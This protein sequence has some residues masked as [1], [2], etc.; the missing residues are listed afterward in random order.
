VII[1][2]GQ[3]QEPYKLPLVPNIRASI[4]SLN[5]LAEAEAYKCSVIAEVWFLF[6]LL[7]K[8]A[9]LNVYPIQPKN[10]EKLLATMIEN[11]EKVSSFIVA[12]TLQLSDVFAFS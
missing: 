2:I 3:Y 5:P 6:V 11:E 8:T 10:V 9:I 12:F 7:F 1:E 4:L